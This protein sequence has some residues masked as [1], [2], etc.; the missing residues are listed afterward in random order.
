MNKMI[1][2]VGAIVLGLCTACSTSLFAN[3]LGPRLEGAWQP[4]DYGTRVEITGDTLLLLWRNAPVL[5]TKFSVSREGG[6]YV[7]HLE[8]TEQRDARDGRVYGHVTGC[9]VEDGVMHL[10]QRYEIAGDD[11]ELLRPTK[12]SRYGDVTLVTE[13]YLPR[14]RGLWRTKD[15]GRWELEIVGETLRYRDGREGEWRETI[16]I[17]V[18]RDTDEPERIR[19]VHRD[20][21]EENVACFFELKYV[22]DRLVA[23][24]IIADGDSPKIVFEKVK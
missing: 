17:V 10:L 4:D 24:E 11:E 7:L 8:K 15:G 5:E 14:L 12:E 1:L 13:K 19:I 21:S 3:V 2:L 16:P 20:P 23:R 9:W 18:T 6:K 22:R